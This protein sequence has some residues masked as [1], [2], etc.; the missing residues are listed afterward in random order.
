MINPLT[1]PI[2]AAGRYRYNYRERPGHMVPDQ[3]RGQHPT[4]ACY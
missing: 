3:F 4:E 1:R 2:T